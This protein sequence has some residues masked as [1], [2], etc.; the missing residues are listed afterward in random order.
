MSSLS[1]LNEVEVA[2]MGGMSIHEPAL[3][4]SGTGV[5]SKYYDLNWYSK[6]VIY[7][8][9]GIKSK[10]SA[11]LFNLDEGIWSSVIQSKY[12]ESELDFNDKKAIIL[13]GS[14]IEVISNEAFDTSLLETFLAKVRNNVTESF[15]NSFETLILIFKKDK[16]LMIASLNLK[17]SWYSLH[18][19]VINDDTYIL[20]PKADI[21]SSS[22]VEFMYQFNNSYED[23]MN[24]TVN[25]SNQDIKYLGFDLDENLSLREMYDIV[26]KNMRCAITLDEEGFIASISGMSTENSNIL[27]NFFNSFGLTFKSLKKLS[28]LRKTFRTSK[29]SSGIMLKIITQEIGSE[30]LNVSGYTIANVCNICSTEEFDKKVIDEELRK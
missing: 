24:N 17:G 12:N 9:L 23:F 28:Y 19:G 6:S 5:E 13:R 20:F 1:I 25:I 26:F 21:E 2:S 29:I 3:L 4:K 22:F 16:A 7:K 11:D 30:A 15:I 8:E 10:L 14:I 27:V 18:S